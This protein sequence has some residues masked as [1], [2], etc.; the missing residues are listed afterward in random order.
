MNPIHVR[1]GKVE[2]DFEPA[3]GYLRYVRVGS[4]ELIRGIYGAVR[5]ADW[6]TPTNRMTS[7]GQ[8]SSNKTWK[9]NWTAR[10]SEGDVQFDWRGS[11]SAVLTENRVE[12]EYEFEGEGKS[13]FKS[14]RTGICVLHPRSHQGMKCEVEHNHGECDQTAFPKSIK[15]DQPFK[16]VKAISLD[17]APGIHVRTEFF[18][19]VFETEDQRN[20]SDASYKTYSRPQ[21]WQKPFDIKSGDKIHQ[22]VKVVIDLATVKLEIKLQAHQGKLP[23]LGTFVNRTLSES[24]T[25]SLRSLGLGCWLAGANGIEQAKTLGGPVFLQTEVASYPAE[26][27]PND[28]I[29]LAPPGE[30]QKLNRVRGGKRLSTAT[31]AFMQLNGSRPAYDEIEGSAWSVRPDIHLPDTLTCLEGGWTI[32]D[33]IQTARGFGSKTNLVGPIEF[34]NDP[35]DP[36]LNTIEAALYAL[37]AITGAAKGH[38]DYAIFADGSRL[39]QSGFALA[40]DL[41]KG[42]EGE[43]EIHEWE[44][45]FLMIRG[46][47]TILANFGW[48]PTDL[49]K[50]CPIDRPENMENGMRNAY[51]LITADNFADWRKILSG[52]ESH[53]PL[54]MIPPRSIVVM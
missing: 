46:S 15:P 47:R 17:V 53:N 14:N 20:Y 3:S 4:V 27:S 19:E 18:G 52:P 30:W 25:E 42:S 11:V 7:T 23:S 5:K 29:C 34:S 39:P 31:W 38:A 49:Y 35:T 12:I 1:L 36:R 28:G 40:L 26:L 33:Q 50:Q 44:P 13:D 6:G 54:T 51:R 32:Q 41:L 16:D 24:E 37:G 9:A 10:V 2:F 21:E 45:F 8:Q 43:I 48:V 22:R